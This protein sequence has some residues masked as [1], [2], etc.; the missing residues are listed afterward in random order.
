MPSRLHPPTCRGPDGFDML[1]GACSKAVHSTWAITPRGRPTFL[2]RPFVN[3]DRVCPNAAAAVLF[4]VTNAMDFTIR[5]NGL[6]L[7]RDTGSAVD[8]LAALNSAGLQEE[9]PPHIVVFD[10]CVHMWL[11]VAAVPTTTGRFLVP[12]HIRGVEGATTTLAFN[13]PLHLRVEKGRQ[14]VD[15]LVCAALAKPRNHGVIASQPQ[16]VAVDII[17]MCEHAVHLAERRLTLS[18]YADTMR[19]IGHKATGARVKKT[20]GKQATVAAPVFSS[21]EFRALD[22]VGGFDDR[23]LDKIVM[24]WG[25]SLAQTLVCFPTLASERSMIQ[26]VMATRH[27]AVLRKALTVAGTPTM[28]LLENATKAVVRAMDHV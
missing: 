3:L 5:V 19:K 8:S 26:R 25:W 14:A 16:R 10:G 9:H 20:S 2:S 22:K 7:A 27:D 18:F 21:A 6:C 15:A 28:L 23:A 4:Y 17:T 11:P 13:M 12:I 1:P 24:P